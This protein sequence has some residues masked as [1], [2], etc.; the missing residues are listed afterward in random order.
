LVPLPERFFAGGGNSHRGFAINQAGPR[1]LTT[2]FPL[3]GEAMFL[4]NVELRLPP[5]ALPFIGESIS[6]VIFHDMGNVFSSTT[7][8][9]R[10][11]F[12]TSQRFKSSCAST[13]PGVNAACDFNYMSHAVGAGVRY[14]TPIGPVR[15][16]FGYNLNPP[17]F[18]VNRDA[19]TET[20][21][22]FNFFFSIGQ[23]F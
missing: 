6:A 20:L 17:T 13:V 2:G 22:R 11:L 18:P 4:N 23:T 1:D 14:R 10:S 16:D 5:V 8:M 15:V 12:R 21:K 9:F 19:R 3:G 7:D